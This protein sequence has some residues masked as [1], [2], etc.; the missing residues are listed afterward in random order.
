MRKRAFLFLFIFFGLQSFAQ[1]YD[2]KSVNLQGMGYVTGLIIHP[3][4]VNAP[5][6]IY[7]RTDVGGAYRFDPLLQKWIPLLDFSSFS[8]KGQMSVESMAIDPANPTVVYAAVDGTNGAGGEILRS[9]NQGSTWQATGLETNKIYIAGNDPYRGSTGER[10][11]VDPNNSDVIYFASRKDG[12]WRKSGV[13]VWSKVTGGLPATA[14]NPGFTFVLF[15]KNSANNGKSQNIYAGCYGSGVWKSEDAGTTW[16]NLLGGTNCLRA[17]LSS[18]TTLYVTFGGDEQSYSGPGKVAKFYNGVWSIITPPSGTGI[19]YSGICTDPIN[20]Q[21]VVVTTHQR[22]MYYSTNG[23][24]KWTSIN[25]SFTYYPAYYNSGVSSFNWGTAALVIDPNNNRRLWSTNGYGVI[26]T[27]D[28]TGTTS[29]WTAVMNNLEEIC[30][31]QI[32]VPPLAGGADLLTCV[33]DMVGFRHQSRDTIPTKKI[34][35]FPYVSMGVSMDYCFTKPNNIVFIGLAETSAD[36]Y[37]GYSTDNGKTWKSFSA[38]PGK[39]GKIAISATNEKNW[40]WVPDGS[41]TPPQYTI[42]AGLTWT[43][44][45]GITGPWHMSTWGIMSY[46][47]S[48]K[49]NGAK[50][51]YNNNGKM[52]YSADSGATWTA[53][54]SGLPAWPHGIFLKA[55]PYHEGEIWSTLVPNSPPATQRIYISKDGGK[56]FSLLNTVAYAYNI[57][58]GKGEFDNIPYVYMSGKVGT[59]A[60]GIY[61]STDEGKTWSLISDPTKLKFTE[62]IEADLRYKDLIYTG[63]AGCRGIF[64][65]Y[66]QGL[67]VNIRTIERKNEIEVFPNPFFDNIQIKSER[68]IQSVTIID[69]TGKEFLSVKPNTVSVSLPVASLKPGYYILRTVSNNKNEVFKIVKTN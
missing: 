66:P 37:R 23:G 45:I 56:T 47:T 64:Y 26:K 31:M 27:D 63:G 2:W 53:G 60:E 50:F 68:E 46:L 13:E 8:Q 3:D 29:K 55:H 67:K 7:V 65:G 22:S 5:D 28:Y 62:N 43:P 1:Q 12:L 32:C 19:S 48:D 6:L 54:Y 10:L 57:A 34:A 11:M 21:T 16:T 61:K 20:P 25:P 44:C 38:T 15:D 58:F 39:G 36:S 49:V 35:V 33:M 41:T 18:D 14:T 69:I 9:A 30:L 42:D 40:V 51:Y 52:F 59:Q 4:I 17:S 24:A